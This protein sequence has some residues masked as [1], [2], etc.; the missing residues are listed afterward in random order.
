M[1]ATILVRLLHAVR[2]LMGVL[3]GDRVSPVCLGHLPFSIKTDRGELKIKP[4]NTEFCWPF[5]AAFSALVKKLW[6]LRLTSLTR[7]CLRVSWF[8]QPFF[9]QNIGYAFVIICL[10]LLADFLR[11]SL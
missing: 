2:Y 4:K 11:Y 3:S 6:L 8:R 9:L 10:S 7:L 1:V 5:I